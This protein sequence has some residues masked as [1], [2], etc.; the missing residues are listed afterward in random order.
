MRVKF[1]SVLCVLLGPAVVAAVGHAAAAEPEAMLTLNATE[2][3][4]AALSPHV[5]D[6]TVA[7]QPGVDATGRPV[8]PADLHDP[9]RLDLTEEDAVIRLR[10]PLAEF[11][12]IPDG[13]E[14][15][16]GDGQIDV[17]DVTI[18]DGIVHLGGRPLS[19]PTAHAL[20]E[21]CTEIL[22]GVR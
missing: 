12:S 20:A 8:A 21:A 7:Y 16:I 3:A 14:T 2:D 18:R 6:D 22:S 5:P 10:I 9:Y 13:L 15:I 17:G 19:N 11:A 1:S 4:C